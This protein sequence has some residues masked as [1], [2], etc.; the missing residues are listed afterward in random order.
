MQHRSEP[1]TIK[2]AHKLCKF[3][4]FTAGIISIQWFHKVK[5]KIVLQVLTLY[6]DIFFKTSFRMAHMFPDCLGEIDVVSSAENIKNLLK[7]PYSSKSGIS[8]MI[9]RIENTLLIDEFDI[10]KYLLRQADDDWKWLKSF[11]GE[12]VL[13]SLGNSERRLFIKN[14]SREAL[15]KKKLLS[16]FLHYSLTDGDDGETAS[17][18]NTSE[19]KRNEKRTPLQLTGPLLPEP[20][21]EE[22]VPDPKTNHIYSRN[23]AWTFED[24][25]MLIGTDMPIFGSAHRP[26]IS[27][28]LRDQSQPIN[29]LTG[30]DYWLDN[31][32]CNV[33]EV[34]MC[35]HL[36]GLVQKY[37]I[38]KTED[39]PYLEN[40]NFSPKVIRNVAQNILAFLKQNATK[41]GH[42]YW[43]FK[44]RND[45]FVKLYDLTSLC[46]N[47]ETATAPAST[48][49]TAAADSNDN[50]FTVPVAMLLYK[51]ARNMKNMSATNMSA[52]QAGSIKTLL[53]NCIQLLPKEKY[54]QIVT[55]SHYILSDLHVPASIN[56]NAPNFSWSDE[57][58]E[59]SQS[60][61]DDDQQ[62]PSRAESEFELNS[63][64]EQAVVSDSP[65]R[66]SIVDCVIGENVAIKNISETLNE[67]NT[68][69]NWKHNTSPPPIVG[70][71]TERCMVA[72]HHIVIGLD[73]L[74]YFNTQ[75]EEKLTQEEKIAKE[76]EKRKIILEELNPNM[77][78]SYQAIPLPYE[79]LKPEPSLDPSK[80]IPMGWK[81]ETPTTTTAASK[82]SKKNRRKSAAAKRLAASADVVGDLA[83]NDFEEAVDSPRSLLLKGK[84]GVIESWNVHL[85]LL[86]LEKTCL[87]YATLTE[88]AY[89]NGQY[90]TSLRYICIA[91]QAQHIVTKHMSSVSSQK[92]CLLG[93]A[94]DCYFQMAKNV[95]S[96]TT[97][98]TDFVRCDAVDVAIR[99]EL[100]KHLEASESEEIIANELC[101]EWEL[102]T[103]TNNIEQLMVS[104]CAC[105]ESALTC[106]TAAASR[107]EFVS[108]LGSVRNELGIRYMHWAQQEYARFVDG[109]GAEIDST[110][111]DSNKP[112]PEE[113]YQIF[114]Q[115]SYDCLVRGVAAFEEISDNAN[116][117]ILMCNMGRF[118][119][120]RAHVIMFNER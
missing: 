68:E 48:S 39:L 36:D 61:Y 78:K 22:N 1:A 7:L 107:R 34:V 5:Y 54:P 20:S 74:Q 42:T 89:H 106:S 28:R 38:I 105:Y 12:N 101:A 13:T 73:C 67:F 40:S 119:R 19:N 95:E 63:C 72:L 52:K 82:K 92:Q 117:A 77:A 116:L 97:N 59:D 30:I 80:P 70:N 66:G 108:R 71:V 102:P 109:I 111:I 98:L 10:H 45:D 76:E 44:G 118:M 58:A 87:T 115:K 50:P 90:G 120:F 8:M 60:M 32:M 6:K 14:K 99:R 62:Q 21:V 16:K 79:K 100:D 112:Q 43:L 64:S 27:L 51:V 56:P 37:E 24:I 15:Q 103:P 26:C 17:S 114:V 29:V 31:L 93:R 46:S 3:L 4:R 85:K 49:T 83:Y 75:S 69:K 23:V 81:V 33:P 57:T 25:R 84:S 65:R 86:L 55:S 94:G 110:V 96:I 18:T 47:G 41:A 35:Y 91:M 9:H 53:D 88:Q 11:I 104:S 2:L 113:L